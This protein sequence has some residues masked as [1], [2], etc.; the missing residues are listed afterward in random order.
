MKSENI[1]EIAKALRAVGIPPQLDADQSRLL[2]R[3]WQRLTDGSP[4]TPGQIE[5]IFSAIR[6]PF[7]AGNA[8]INRVSERDGEGNVVGIF[9]LSQLKHPHRFR[10]KGHTFSTWCA[11]DTLFLPVFLKQTATIKTYCPATKEKIQL[12]ITPEKVEQVAP[13][14]TVLSMVVPEIAKGGCDSSEEIRCSFCHFVHFISSPEIANEWVSEKNRD[15]A[16]LFVE[17]GYRL[18]QLVFEELHKYI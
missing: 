1:A 16:I 11:W 13:S 12:T 4:I 7:D 9:G 3:V 8:F 6:I 10:V 5:Q 15:I 14:G 18:G 17:E 2:I